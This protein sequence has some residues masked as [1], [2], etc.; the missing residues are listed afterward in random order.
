MRI[1]LIFAENAHT[2]ENLTEQWLSSGSD[3]DK[4][5]RS[6][7]LRTHTSDEFLLPSAIERRIGNHSDIQIAVST[8]FSFCSR[9]ENDCQH[10]FGML[11]E[12]PP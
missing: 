12:Q 5:D 7:A 10:N 9:T 6:S 3:I 2:P 1:D 8:I 11:A 4:I